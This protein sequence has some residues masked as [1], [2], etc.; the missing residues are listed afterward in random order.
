M[1][2]SFYGPHY[3]SFA[4]GNLLGTNAHLVISSLIL[5]ILLILMISSYFLNLSP[6]TYKSLIKKGLGVFFAALCGVQLIGLF[7][8]HTSEIIK[9][10]S[11]PVE[12]RTPEILQYTKSFAEFVKF[13]IGPRSYQTAAQIESDLNQDGEI[14]MILLSFFA[15]YLYPIDSKSIR[16]NNSQT[17]KLGFFA[18]LDQDQRLNEDQRLYL[19]DHGYLLK[20]LIP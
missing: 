14:N 11:T 10:E 20:K 16:E 5:G 15:Y 2:N 6:S 18:D 19:Y 4:S 3:N 1:I 13:H 9:F 17:I 7:N 8:F 12:Y